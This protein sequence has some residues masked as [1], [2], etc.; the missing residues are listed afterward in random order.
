MPS[1]NMPSPI[2]M[3]GIV[4]KRL[5]TRHIPP[6]IINNLEIIF[7]KKTIIFKFK[8]SRAIKSSPEE[9]FGVT[10]T[11]I[12]EGLNRGA[13][14]SKKKKEIPIIP[15]AIEAPRV[16]LIKKTMPTIKYTTE[17]IKLITAANLR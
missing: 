5:T 17:K 3:Y 6:P 15:T 2:Y 12:R 9:L 8:E 11:F 10:T 4:S 16:P 13:V 14:L 7:S 1:V